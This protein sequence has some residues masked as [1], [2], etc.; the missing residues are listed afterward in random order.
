MTYTCT[1][2]DAAGFQFTLWDGT[3][4]TQCPIPP[5]EIALLHPSFIARPLVECG[6]RIV[7]TPV[8]QEFGNHTSDATIAVLTSNNG[9]TVKCSLDCHQL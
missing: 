9:S 3:A 7:A 8:S 4:F 1:V 5:N 2:E 6:D